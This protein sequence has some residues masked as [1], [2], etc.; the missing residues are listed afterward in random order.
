MFS[1]SI[2]EHPLLVYLTALPFTPINTL[3]Y[4]TFVTDDIP[5]IVGGF[6]QSWSPL[7]HMFQAHENAVWS[8]AYFPDGTRIATS[9]DNSVIRIW[10]VISGSEIISPLAGHVKDGVRCLA[11]SSDGLCS[12]RLVRLHCPSVGYNHWC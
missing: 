4:S 12:L 3:L 11:V 9:S 1:G 8:L 7:L 2:E 5:R 10:D 6:T